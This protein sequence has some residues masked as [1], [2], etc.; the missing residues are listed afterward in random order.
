M[1]LPTMPGSRISHRGEPAVSAVAVTPSDSADLAATPTR[2]LYI[3]TTGNLVVNMAD[4]TSVTFT[5][6]PVGILWISVDRVKATGT[7]ASNIIAL[8]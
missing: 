4:D 1:P 8:Y 7:T 6:V 5:A 2:A 3:G